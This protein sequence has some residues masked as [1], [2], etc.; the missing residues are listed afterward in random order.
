MQ[1]S[2]I[3]KQFNRSKPCYYCGAPPPSSKEH[4]PVKSMFEA[5]DCDSITVPA[6]DRHNTAKNLDDRAIV[7]FFLRGLYTGFKSGTLTENVLRAF[8]VA[9]RNLKNARE[10][11]LRPL[12]VD[13][14][15]ELDTPLSHIDETAKVKAWMRQLTAAL[16][17]SVVGEFD[18]S[19]RWDDAVVWSPEFAPD[20]GLLNIEEAK[21][22]IERLQSIKSNINSL[23]VQWWPGW[24]SFPREYPRDIYRFELSFIPS[25]Y[26]LRDESDT[27]I[28]FRHWFYSQFSWFV[29]FTAP[30]QV[31]LLIMNTVKKMHST[32]S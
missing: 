29:W 23:A 11:T 5:F 31:R 1:D 13:P 25:Q 24:S 16:V 32:E 7:A 14:I 19:V 12:V 27:G 28:I 10:V 4:A 26:L 8:E 3:V 9:E 18:P 17:W 20:T 21:L 30:Q 2:S 15:G 6:C 22:R